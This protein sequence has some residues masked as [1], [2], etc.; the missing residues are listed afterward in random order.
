MRHDRHNP[1]DPL[2]AE[3]GEARERALE[4]A[5]AGGTDP[6]A[7]A[8]L[9]RRRTRGRLAQRRLQR[10]GAVLVPALLALAL[11]LELWAT[12]VVVH[13]EEE[14]ALATLLLLDEPMLPS[15]AWD[16]PLALN[17]EVEP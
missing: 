11:G 9:V 2:V 4:A 3:F 14:Q 1:L 17:W 10:A 8:A 12:R 13:L 16:D 7:V 6:A 15:E 5:A